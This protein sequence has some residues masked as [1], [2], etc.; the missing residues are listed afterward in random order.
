M[1]QA[2]LPIFGTGICDSQRNPS[3]F[4]CPLT[5]D[6]ATISLA[7]QSFTLLQGFQKSIIKLT[8]VVLSDMSQPPLTYYHNIVQKGCNLNASID[9]GQ[10]KH[11]LHSKL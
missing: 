6:S 4:D 8:F 10:A 1:P 2:G 3:D 5:F 9:S 11:E 7:G